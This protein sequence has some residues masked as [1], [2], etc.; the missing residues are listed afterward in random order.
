MIWCETNK[1]DYVIDLA[2]NNRLNAEIKRELEEAKKQRPKT[3]AYEYKLSN[4]YTSH[5]SHGYRFVALLY[6]VE[7]KT[8]Y[9]QD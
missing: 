3:N 4:A 8:V 9:H 6:T 2:K 7:L 1:V 5:R